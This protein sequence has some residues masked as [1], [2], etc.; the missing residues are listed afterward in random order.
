MDF[1]TY[2]IRWRL[3]TRDAAHDVLRRAGRRMA[4]LRIYD[5]GRVR[6]AA[7]L[8]G[9][10]GTVGSENGRHVNDGTAG[11]KKKRYFFDV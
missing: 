5:L 3:T 8:L 7:H 2:K 9:R 11:D 6:L 1:H 10:I 4:A